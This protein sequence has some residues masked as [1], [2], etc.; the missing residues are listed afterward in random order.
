MWGFKGKGLATFSKVGTNNDVSLI[1][2]TFQLLK[3]EVKDI[4]VISIY[5]SSDCSKLETVVDFIF[6]YKAE[7][8]VVLGDFNFTPDVSNVLTNHLQDWAFNQLVKLPTHIDGNILD[9]CYVSNALS[10]S[11]FTDLHYVYYSDHQGILITI[12]EQ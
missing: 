9:H 3:T 1:D 7:K 2:E 5:L 11:T 10:N 6:K 12:T 4:T 8:C